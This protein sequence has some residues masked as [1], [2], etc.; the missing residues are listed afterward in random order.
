MGQVCCPAGADGQDGAGVQK[1]LPARMEHKVLLAPLVLTA[2]TE[3]KVKKVLPARMEHKVLLAPLVLTAKTEHKVLLA[4]LVPAAEW[5]GKVQKVSRRGWSTRS[6]WPR[7]CWLTKTVHK[8]PQA[9]QARMSTGPAGPAGAD[10][11]D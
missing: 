10:S 7:W 6:C 4:P 5:C 9:L 2:K 8:G 11:Q 3:H 1:V